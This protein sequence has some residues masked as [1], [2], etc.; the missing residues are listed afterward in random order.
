MR[1]L[2]LLLVLPA[3]APPPQADPDFSDAARFLFREFEDPE[4]ANLAFALR[5]VE[6]SW[7]DQADLDSDDN[8]D[9]ALTPNFLTLDDIAD[10]DT[11]G[12]DPELGLA[13]AVARWSTHAPPQH[14][15]IQLLADHT[16]VEPNSPT[17]YDRTF[18]EGTED[19]W[20]DRGCTTLRT[21]N[22]ILKE[23]VVLAIPY[24]MRKDIRW[25]DLGLPDPSTVAEGEA[26]V[27]PDAPQWGLLGRSWVVEEA[28]ND[29]GPEVLVGQYSLETW[30]PQAEGGA[31]RSMSFWFDLEGGAL[32]DDIQINTARNGIDDI[33]AVGD[34]W[35]DA[36]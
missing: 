23:N 22:Q 30:I 32:T 31:L 15:A 7:K 1:I 6:A 20:A 27:N 36:R 24:E 34:E 10:L 9:R 28:P 29:T 21:T 35:L 11:P 4:P 25:I 8:Q 26:V 14:T 16:P 2:A 3:C 12:H 18:L 19:C 33:F 13:I 17:T 5:A